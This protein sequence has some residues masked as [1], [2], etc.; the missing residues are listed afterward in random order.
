MQCK[1]PAFERHMRGGHHALRLENHN[2]I[3]LRLLAKGAGEKR[4]Q[5]RVLVQGL[6]L[7]AGIVRIMIGDSVG[8]GARV[9][10]ASLSARLAH[11]RLFGLDNLTTRV[12]EWILGDWI[13][14]T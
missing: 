11:E 13:R 7:D 1:A 4:L 9:A 3:V 8:M 12:L 10:V 6:K 5:G 2:F 14:A